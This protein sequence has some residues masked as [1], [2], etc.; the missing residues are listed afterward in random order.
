MVWSMGVKEGGYFNSRSI[1]SNVVTLRR[2]TC[3]TLESNGATRDVHTVPVSKNTVT[4]ASSKAAAA[5]EE[6]SSPPASFAV[7]EAVLTRKLRTWLLLPCEESEFEFRLLLPLLFP[8]LP[9]LLVVVLLW[10]A[11]RRTDTPG[12]M[13]DDE[14]DGCGAAGCG[15]TGTTR[16]PAID[17]ALRS[18]ASRSST[19]SAAAAAD[20]GREDEGDRD[21]EEVS[22]GNAIVSSGSSLEQRRLDCFVFLYYCCV[23]IVDRIAKRTT[24]RYTVFWE[25]EN[26]F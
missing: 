4:R 7:V 19:N 1:A 26:F 23:G 2:N 22:N 20:A 24:H 10:K 13:G 17:D 16:H 21:A 15:S 8:P 5:E 9:L 11:A 25:S 14:G 18:T 6:A 3:R 12:K